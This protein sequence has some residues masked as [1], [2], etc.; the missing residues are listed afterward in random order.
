MTNDDGSVDLDLPN[1]MSSA[2]ANIVKFPGFLT[3]NEEADRLILKYGRPFVG[4]KRPKYFRRR[5]AKACFSNAYTLTM[6]KGGT[7]CEGVAVGKSLGF[8]HAWITL[9]GEDAIDVTLPDAQDHS[10]YGIEFR[11]DQ[12]DRFA[13]SRMKDGFLR[14]ILGYPVDDQLR[15]FLRDMLQRQVI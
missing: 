4:I 15:N 13:A 10:Y 3:G 1:P 2:L 11:S 9:D 14:P 7:Y 12:F 5:A 6:E 8:H